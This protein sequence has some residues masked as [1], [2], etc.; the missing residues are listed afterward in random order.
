MP[1]F[2][3][4]PAS[5]TIAAFAFAALASGSA[6]AQNI[7]IYSNITN[8][9]GAFT[10]T[11]GPTSTT[12]GVTQT[13]FYADDLSYNSSFAGQNINNVSFSV[14]NSDPGSFTARARFRFF[15]SDGANG[16]PGTYITTGYSPLLS[17]VPGNNVFSNFNN[18]SQ[19]NMILPA[20]GK[21]WAGIFFDNGLSGTTP[22]TATAA[23]V[24]SLGQGVYGP[25]SVGSSDN[26]YFVSSGNTGGFTTT[27]AGTIVSGPIG[28]QPAN[29]GWQI[30]V[31]AVPEPSSFGL[32]ALG[33][34]SGG[35][36]LARRRR[37][38]AK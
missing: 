38:S 28:G 4:A 17:F 16:G 26:V 27:P 25:P 20:S 12:T 7:P 10:T 11:Q 34:V 21:L 22:S 8:F 13:A 37:R 18:G 6:H 33:L 36:V 14:Y 1:R 23:Q 30:N 5:K 31:V 32:V 29:F 9:L 19:L 2:I 35:G 3:S 15:N 24:A